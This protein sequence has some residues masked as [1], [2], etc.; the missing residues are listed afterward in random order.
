MELKF[1]KEGYRWYIDLPEYPGDK[2]DLQMV[3][4]ADTLLDTL[5]DSTNNVVIL[6]SLEDYN[7]SDKLVKLRDLTADEGGGAMYFTDKYKFDLWLCDVTKFVFNG[8][9]VEI[10]YSV[11][12]A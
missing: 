3:L 12:K 9:P 7:S 2:A 6:A 11:I 5:S 10:F 4:G 1:Y 8:F